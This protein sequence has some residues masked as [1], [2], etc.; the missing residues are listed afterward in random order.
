MRPRVLVVEDDIL[1]RIEIAETLEE[2]GFEVLEARDVASALTALSAVPDLHLV[3]T[4]VQM[5]GAQDGVAL[6][7]HVRERHPQTKVIVMSAVNNNPALP[8]GVPFLAKPFR[9]AHLVDLAQAQLR[10]PV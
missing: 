3:C 7:I 10:A 4:D 2:A 6:A 8:V 1:V 5:P 9:S